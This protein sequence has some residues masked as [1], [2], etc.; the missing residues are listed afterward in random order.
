MGLTYIKQE[1]D[2]TEISEDHCT[3]LLFCICIVFYM[4]FFIHAVIA[5][6]I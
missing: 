3:I 5:G 6:F 4:K 1:F 2:Q